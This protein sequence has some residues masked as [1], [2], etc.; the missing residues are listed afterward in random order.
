[1]TD[2]KS[3]ITQT[4]FIVGLLALLLYFGPAHALGFGQIRV[5]SALNEPLDATLELV[6]LSSAEKS[7]IRVDVASSDMFARFGIERSALADRLQIDM[8]MSGDNRATVRLTTRSPVREPFLRLLI[9]ATTASGSAL[10]EYTVLLDPPGMAPAPTGESAPAT[11]RRQQ[12]QP[13]TRSASVRAESVDRISQIDRYGPVRRGDTLS[14][15]AERA[16]RPGTSLVQMQIAIFQ[17]NPNAF[18]DSIDRLRSGAMLSIPSTDRVKAVD[19]REAWSIIRGQR[20]NAPA[21]AV[22]DT[23]EKTSATAAVDPPGAATL[24]LQPPQ[25][26]TEGREEDHQADSAFFGRLVMP[27]VGADAPS[28]QQDDAQ[29]TGNT[30]SMH[31]P[32]SAQ[33]DSDRPMASGGESSIADAGLN[34]DDLQPTAAGADALGDSASVAPSTESMAA[35]SSPDRSLGAGS[36]AGLATEPASA[37]GSALVAASED[38]DFEPVTGDATD[39]AGVFGDGLMQP[40]NLMLLAL[41]LCLLVVLSLWHRRRQYKRVELSFDEPDSSDTAP[42]ASTPGGRAQPELDAAPAPGAA[43][44]MPTSGASEIMPAPS[45]R[46]MDADRQMGLGQ[47]DA[48]RRTLEQGLRS[49]PHDPGL[50][51]KLLELSYLVGDNAGFDADV[52]RFGPALADNGVRWAGVAAMGRI[53]MPGD[54]RF[55]IQDSRP[56]AASAPAP[57]S[58]ADSAESGEI[59]TPPLPDASGPRPDVEMPASDSHAPGPASDP[60]VAR[61]DMTFS[62]DE[63]SEPVSSSSDTRQPSWNE[64]LSADNS[65]RVHDDSAVGTT[66][67]EV[68]DWQ[69]SELGAG[70]A[71]EHDQGDD[72]GLEFELDTTPYDADRDSARDDRTERAASRSSNMKM[73]DTSEFDLGDPGVIDDGPSFGEEADTSG[74]DP[75]DIRLELARMYIEMEDGAAARE[76]IEEA[77]IEGN[78]VQQA[79]ARKLLDGL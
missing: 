42:A 51:D 1:V 61:P 32:G 52:A 21:S 68:L 37:P 23:A 15:I 11:P 8:S 45:I 69:P 33:D 56:T 63:T 38:G 20:Q 43:A 49:H 35:L 73:I 12:A 40:R 17:S 4:T 3:W 46:V 27:A 71:R 76:L 62:L 44:A 55:A 34:D 6:A 50:Q 29:A 67:D 36:M 39:V 26:L 47:F 64:D 65:A 10:R 9:Q 13:A 60:D 66:G 53:L 30:G 19:E 59:R 77:M 2:K 74:G 70:R 48:A 24:R 25:S 75:V 78:D 18:D 57:T 31:P 58:V 5:H 54:P 41:L 72:D 14:A 7:S 28:P 16:Q 79:E 22:A